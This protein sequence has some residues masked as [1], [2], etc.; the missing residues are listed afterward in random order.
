MRVNDDASAFSFSSF[1][2]FPE[3][4][5]LIPSETD[6][7]VRGGDLRFFVLFLFRFNLG[8]YHFKEI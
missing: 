2:G 6:G 1:L 5:G 8:I 3:L 7:G 4:T